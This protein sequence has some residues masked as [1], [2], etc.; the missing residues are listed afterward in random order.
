MLQWTYNSC[1]STV[2]LLD[3]EQDPEERMSFC[4]TLGS[5]GFLYPIG[6]R[7]H[8]KKSRDLFPLVVSFSWHVEVPLGFTTF[9]LFLSPSES[10]TFLFFS[11]L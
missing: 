4:E 1:L 11:I 2:K 10:F 6:E 9:F 3:Q 8:L 7:R 5:F